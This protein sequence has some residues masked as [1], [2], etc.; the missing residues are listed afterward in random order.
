MLADGAPP[1]RGIEFI[2]VFLPSSERSPRENSFSISHGF[3]STHDA[4]ETVG[5]ALFAEWD[6][7]RKNIFAACRERYEINL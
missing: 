4:A 5:A 7:Q 3:G 6:S 2:S 1:P